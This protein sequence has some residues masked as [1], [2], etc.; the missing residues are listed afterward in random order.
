M[1]NKKPC[2]AAEAV[3]MVR[4]LNIGG[5]QIGL[6]RLDPIIEE[7]SGLGLND[8]K[9]IKK[10]LLKRIKIHNYV[11]PDAEKDYAEAAF[12]EYSRQVMD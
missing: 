5:T 6:S 7:V 11:P 1:S 12:K 2:C 4:K 3:R 10:D 8:E 9:D